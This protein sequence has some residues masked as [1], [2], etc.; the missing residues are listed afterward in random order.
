M[1]RVGMIRRLCGGTKAVDALTGEEAPDSRRSSI[2]RPLRCLAPLPDFYSIYQARYL[3]GKR[4]IS[5][6]KQNSSLINAALAAG[7]AD[8]I[9]AHGNAV[10]C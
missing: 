3:A 7:L 9:N 6:W 8:Y 2:P 1:S 10:A 4:G 5:R